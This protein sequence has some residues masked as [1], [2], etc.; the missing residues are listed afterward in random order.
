MQLPSGLVWDNAGRIVMI[1]PFSFAMFVVDPKDG[2]IV[3]QYGGYG[4][5]DGQFSYPAAIGYDKARDWF[6]IADTGNNR[7]QIVRIP[8]SG[9]SLASR[10]T[11]SLSG[12]LRAC[13]FPLILILIALGVAIFLRQRRRR[14]EKKAALALGKATSPG[15]VVELSSEDEESL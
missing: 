12:P 8:G 10:A 2:T 4:A 7:V 1:D 3:K 6:A 15:N 11:A 14:E 13:L 5:Q 9:S